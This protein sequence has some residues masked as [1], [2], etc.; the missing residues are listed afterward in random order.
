MKLSDIQN[1]AGDERA[2]IV[3]RKCGCADMRVTRTTRTADGIR[4]ERVCR[5]CGRRHFS[6]ERPYM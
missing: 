6:I 3:C 1:R 5:H 4:R 2:G